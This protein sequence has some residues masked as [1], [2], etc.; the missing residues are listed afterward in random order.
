MYNKT[1]V[2]TQLRVVIIIYNYPRDYIHIY[3][4]STGTIIYLTDC[5]D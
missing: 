3:F 5:F 2:R 1:T 4:F